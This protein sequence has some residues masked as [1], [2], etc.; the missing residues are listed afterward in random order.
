MLREVSESPRMVELPL[1]PLPMVMFPQTIVPLHI[2]EERYKLMINRSIEESSAFGIVMNTPGSSVENESTI[3]RI[4]SSVRVTQFERIEDGRL[5]ILVNGERRFEILEFTGN[6]PYWTANVEFLED[7]LA[8]DDL[9]ESF[10]A[11]A[12]L[13]RDVLKLASRLRGQPAEGITIPESPTALSYAVS[14]VLDLPWSLKQE[15]LEMSSVSGRLK[16]VGVHLE[17]ILQR[18]KSRVAQA[19]KPPRVNGNGR[20]GTVH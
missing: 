11:T 17:A 18:L 2:F 5:N 7:D 19:A 12:R 10:D 4:G 20:N 13:Y 9:Q 8:A 16:S 15:L 6:K 3:S 1:F 14:S